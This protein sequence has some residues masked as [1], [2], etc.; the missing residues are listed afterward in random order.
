MYSASARGCTKPGCRVQTRVHSRDH[1]FPPVPRRRHVFL[2]CQN[3]T[4]GFPAVYKWRQCPTPEVAGGSK[5]AA[6]TQLIPTPPPHPHLQPPSS[7][8]THLPRT[9]GAASQLTL[10]IRRRG[11]GEG[12]GQQ[13]GEGGKRGS[14]TRAEE[15]AVQR[16]IS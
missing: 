11:R 6:H 10:L 5:M 16:K 4:H 8:P 7:P 15:E 13:P 3:I 9:S 1:D 12:G 2:P 14:S